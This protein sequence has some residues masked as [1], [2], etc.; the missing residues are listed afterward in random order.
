MY[1]YRNQQRSRFHSILLRFYRW[2]VVPEYMCEI[3]WVATQLQRR[4]VLLALC[5]S[6]AWQMYDLRILSGLYRLRVLLRRLAGSR[7][8]GRRF[9]FILVRG[10]CDGC[11]LL[12]GRE[13][14]RRVFEA[15][16]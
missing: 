11:G 7:R 1:E 9:Y 8:V 5:H 2:D 3:W 10:G 12:G 15:V 4:W 6:A 13:Y 16:G 14:L